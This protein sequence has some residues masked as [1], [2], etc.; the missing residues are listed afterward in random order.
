MNIQPAVEII[1]YSQSVKTAK[2]AN[3]KEHI[4]TNNKIV[5]K[6]IKQ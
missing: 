6:L 4:M 5:I 2:Q 1:L 3:R